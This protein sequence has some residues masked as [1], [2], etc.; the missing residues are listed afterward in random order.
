MANGIVNARRT[1]QL[2]DDDTLRSIDHE[3]ARLGHQREISHKNFMFVDLV[4]LFIMKADLHF[5]RS[6][7]CGVPLLTLGD[8]IL[9]IVSAQC[10]IHEFQAQLTAVIRDRRDI[11][12][13]FFQALVQK[14]LIGVLLDFDQIRHFQYLFLPRV[15]H[16]HAFSSLDRTYSVFLH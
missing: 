2:A 3:G 15:T 12:K 10:E 4:C 16:T 9:H 7:V 14:P 8:G 13:Y 5:Q 6:C 1:H 11:R